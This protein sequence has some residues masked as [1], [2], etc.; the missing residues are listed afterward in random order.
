M[1]WR[2]EGVLL[3][4]RKHGE[5]GAILEA[6]TAQHGRHSGLM[7]GG[8][9][10]KNA[11]LRQPGAQLSLT[12]RA[13][14]EGRLGV[15]R[16]EPIKGRAAA[17]FDDPL[18]LAALSSACALLSTFLPEREPQPELYPVTLKMFDALAAGG[19]WTGVYAVW[20]LELLKAL[21]YGLDLESCAATGATQELIWVSPKSGRAVS[22][23]AGEPYADR[24]LPLP[25]AFRL[26]EPLGAEDFAASLRLTGH[27]LTR[28]P[29]AALG[30]EA[31]PAARG[32]L[33]KL[34][35]RAVL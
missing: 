1:E 12:W 32:R 26:H 28:W 30:L 13:R 15:Y 18:A 6:F 25:Q 4:A 14:L 27:F 10:R 20:E 19:N 29:V 3:S 34:S 8:A 23:S 2:D 5:T 9:S 24:L 35:E 11:A 17:V 21:G 7:Q 33:Q 22:R 31:A 16:A